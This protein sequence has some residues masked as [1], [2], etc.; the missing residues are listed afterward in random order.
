MKGQEGTKE[1]D[2]LIQEDWDT[3]STV[4][5]FRDELVHLQKSLQGQ[6][7]PVNN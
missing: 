6:R 7:S 2:A 3:I 5:D 1:I 4:M